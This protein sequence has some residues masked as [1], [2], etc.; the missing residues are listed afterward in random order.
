MKLRNLVLSYSFP[1]SVCRKIGFE[2]LR[3]RLQMNNV[4]TWARNSLGIDPEA[5][6]LT[7]GSRYARTP[8]SYTMS[9]YFN[10]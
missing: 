8:R 5:I 7:S 10:L 6:G 4:C 9:L 1:S 3:L 2:N